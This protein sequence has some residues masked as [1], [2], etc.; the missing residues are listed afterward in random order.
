[1]NKVICPYCGAEYLP[2]EIFILSNFNEHRIIKDEYGKLLEEFEYDN[3]ESYRCDYCDRT[4][5]ATLNIDIESRERTHPE[6]IITR[7]HKPAL[8]LDE[9]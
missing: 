1:M 4:F 6:Q 9:E 2:Q 7:L 3:D 8:F 5:Y